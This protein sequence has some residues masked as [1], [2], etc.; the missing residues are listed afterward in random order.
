M[1]EKR[2]MGVGCESCH[3]PA[4]AHVQARKLSA[5][6]PIM[7]KLHTA[8]GSRISELC[9]ECHGTEK[10]VIER[11]MNRS[12]TQRFQPYGLAMSR[13]FQ[14]SADKLT[15][16][17]C[18]DPHT[19]V[20]TNFKKYEAACLKC[21]SGPKAQPASQLIMARQCPVNASSNCV[22]CHMPLKK[23]FQFS[24]IPVYMRDHYIRIHKVSK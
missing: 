20:S 5:S 1:P 13:C 9:G 3:G 21:H 22:G 11:N 15:C 24:T 19:D 7:E 12:S 4:G 10:V 8:G 23:A 2:F 18:H 17:T 6:G 14:E 16:T